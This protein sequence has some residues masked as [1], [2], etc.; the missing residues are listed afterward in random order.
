MPR[1]SSARA[2]PWISASDSEKFANRTVNHS[3]SA[4]WRSNRG[5][6][7]RH[8]ASTITCTVTNRAPIQTTN[9][10]GF[11]SSS[12]GSSFA[13]ALAIARRCTRQLL[14]RMSLRTTCPLSECR[15]PQGQEMLDDG[16]QEQLREEAQAR[17]DEDA[18]D[19]EHDE[20]R[21]LGPEGS[22]L[23]G[24]G[25]FSARLPAM[26]TTGTITTNLPS[27]MAKAPAVL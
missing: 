6:T 22:L 13:N 24:I 10:T 7:P 18:H 27:S 4:I 8:A 5:N 25:I 1:S 14:S 16:P 20:G 15:S 26:T 21:A 11:R 12:R 17:D 2:L 3:Q 9:M 19:Q 23:G